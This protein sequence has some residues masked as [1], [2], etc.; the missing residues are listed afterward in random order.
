MLAIARR[1]KI[2]EYIN[3]SKYVSV[4]ELA[5]EFN[6]TQETIR[7]DLKVLEGQNVLIRSY[8]GA[9]SPDGVEN[10]VSADL[11]EH[12]H[13]DG[14]QRIAEQCCDLVSS[15][16]SVFLDA[17]TTSLFIAE[18]LKDKTFTVITNSLKI[19]NA[20]ADISSIKLVLIGGGLDRNSMSFL[21]ASAARMMEQYHF[22]L[23][24]LSCRSLDLH[25][26]LMDSNEQQAEIRRRAIERANRSILVVDYTKLN[27]TAFCDIAPLD[28]VDTLVVDT[29]LDDAWRAYLDGHGVQY[30]DG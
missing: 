21:G 10:D 7:R 14:K 9:Y 18:R 4:A 6:V 17:S 2:K 11:R 24:I 15:G 3:F 16:D 30:I 25:H 27:R 5:A 13:V 28:S 19:L 12:I 20:L 22:D 1:N 8:G 26:G 23:S 29:R